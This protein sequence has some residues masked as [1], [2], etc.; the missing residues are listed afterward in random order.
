MTE[1][2]RLREL[3][4]ARAALADAYRRGAEAMREAASDG[5]DCND[6]E[7]LCCYGGTDRVR[8]T[9]IPEDK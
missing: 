1:N 3:Q 5:L 6:P 7:C 9:P 2:Q 8:S 4:E